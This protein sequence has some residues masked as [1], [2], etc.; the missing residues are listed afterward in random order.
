MKTKCLLFFCLIVFSINNLHAQNFSNKGKDFWL[1]YGYHVSMPY[2]SGNT[3]D[4]IIY[5]T[6]DQ[7]ATVKIDIPG[8]GYSRSY[9][10]TANNVTV[11]D[12]VPKNLLLDARITGPGKFNKGIHITSDNPVVAYAHIYD[13]N[14]SGATL[15]FPTNTLGKDYYSVNYTQKSNEENSNSYFFVVA[16]EDSTSIEITPSAENLNNFPVGVPVVVNLNKGEIYNVMGTTELGS[17]SIGWHGSDLTG[18]RIRSISNSNGTCKPIAVFSGSGKMYIGSHVYGNAD[19]FFAQ[20]FPAKAWGTRYL[21]APTL[22]QP[23]NYFRVCV[24]DSTTIVKVNGVA[25]P[26]SS[27]INGFYYQFKNGNQLG[28]NLPRPNLIE[29]DKPILVA[30]Y[31]TTFGEDGNPNASWEYWNY[32]G[33]IGGDPEM[34]YLSPLEQTINNITLYSADRFE[35]ILSFI[36]IIIRKEG[37]ASFK[38]DGVP[39]S[40]STFESHPGDNNYSYAMIPVYSGVSH[41]LYS[42]SGFNAI[43]YGFGDAESYGYNAGTNIIDLEPSIFIRNDSAKSGVVYT[44]TCVGSP[45]KINVAVP[46]IA[47]NFELSIDSNNKLQG[48]NPFS[49]TPHSYDSIYTSNGKTFYIY[50]IPISYKL[51]SVGVFPVKLVVSSATPQSDGCSNNN[52]QEFISNIYVKEAPIAHFTIQSSGCID[53]IVN[54]VD[55]SVGIG[56]PFY[57]WIWNVDNEEFAYSQNAS[58]K[59]TKFLNHFKLTAITDNGCIATST[60]VLSVSNHPIVNIIAPAVACNNSMIRFF[61]SSYLLAD[62]SFNYLHERIWKI[63]DKSTI[64]TLLTL[65]TVFNQFA[66]IGIKKIQLTVK[67]NTGCSATQLKQI[68]INELPEIPTITSD[69]VCLGE[70]AA[71]SANSSGIIEWYDATIGGHLIK[72][73]NT[74]II[75][76]LSHDTMFFVQS[77]VQGCPASNR[78]VAYVKVNPIPV[79]IDVKN[80]VVCEGEK[81]RLVVH[82]TGLNEWYDA[83][84]NGNMVYSGDTVLT[85][86]LTKDTSFFVKLSLNGCESYN[87]IRVFASVKNNPIIAQ[88]TSDTICIGETAQLIGSSTGML[89][90]YDAPTDGNLLT[91]GSHF[92]INNLLVDTFFYAQ[93]FFNGC[94][95]GVRSIAHVKVNPIPSIPLV[96]NDTICVGEIANI[97]ANSNGSIHWYTELV[98]GNMLGTSNNFTATDLSEDTVYYAQ[99]ILNGCANPVRSP[100]LVKVNNMPTT[101]IVFNDTVCQGQDATL[102][103][104]SNG[105]IQWFNQSV[106]GNI[107]FIGDS[108]LKNNIYSDTIFYTR[109]VL[110]GCNSAFIQAHI[111]VNTIPHSPIVTNDTVCKGDVTLLT[112]SSNGTN[113]W[114]NT[115]SGGNPFFVGDTLINVN[116]IY[117]TILYV[118]SFL[119]GCTDS[120]RTATFVKVN[121]IPAP[122]YVNSDTICYDHST[123]LRAN[124][125]GNNVWFDALTGGNIIFN[126]NEFTTDNL[127]SDTTFYV[128]SFLNGCN[129]LIRTK[130]NIKVNEL[131]LT[132]VIINDTI[133][134]GETAKISAF[135]NGDILWYDAPVNGTI[136]NYGD[137]FVVHHLMQD[138]SLFVQAILKGCKS[139]NNALANIKVNKIPTTPIVTTD[140]ICAGNKSALIAASSGNNSWFD[141]NVGGNIIYEGNT[142]HTNELFQDSI[143][144]VQSFLNGCTNN[145]RSPSSVKVKQLPSAPI[146]TNDTICEGNIPFISAISSYTIEWFSSSSEGNVISANDTFSPIGLNHDTSFYVQ[147]TLNGCISATRTKSTIIVNP[148]PTI[149]TI[150]NDTICEGEVALLKAQSNGNIYWY[151][152]QVGGSLIGVGDTYQST[153]LNNDSF[154]Y[155]HAVL[156]GCTIPQRKI[157]E[158]KVNTVPSTPIVFNDSICSGKT[159][160]LVAT[161]NGNNLW[162]KDSIGGNLIVVNN[163]FETNSLYDDTS[164][165]VQSELN[166]CTNFIRSKA[167][168]IIKPSPPIPIINNDT[169]LCETS[170]VSLHIQP[171]TNASY[172]WSGPLDFS[173]DSANYLLAHLNVLNSGLYQATILLNGCISPVSTMSLTVFPKPENPSILN[174]SPICLNDTLRFF[175]NHINGAIYSWSGP[176]QFKSNEEQPKFKVLNGVDSGN[177][178]LNLTVNNCKSDTV[179]SA[180]KIVVPAISDAGSNQTICSN[181]S[182]IKLTGNIIGG[183]SI[184][185]WTTNGKGYF[186]FNRNN[187]SNEYVL[188]EKD[189]ENNQLQFYLTSTSNN[190]CSADTDSLTVTLAQAP[191]ISI[192]PVLKIFENDTMQLKP[193]IAGNIL[194]YEWSPASFLSNAVIKQPI[195]KGVQDQLLQLKVISADNCVSTSL[196]KTIILKPLIIPN[197]FSPNADGIHDTWLIPGLNNYDG[198]TVNIFDRTGKIVFSSTGYNTPWDGTY[199]GKPLPLATYYY[200]INTMSGKGMYTGSITILR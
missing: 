24:K 37:V 133:C 132:P 92:L 54:L 87:R 55:Q 98:N 93:A 145:V 102:S 8:I 125:S 190:N 94:S 123:T 57:K 76:G 160:T 75:E 56:S 49:Y 130:A 86:A 2:G 90:W 176:N 63:D 27:L 114:Y 61:D 200:I 111:Y 103:A 173:T 169:I 13:Q 127:I 140:T 138:S 142:L 180:V 71:L 188:N 33:Y 53:S 58:I 91:S 165:Y 18:S 72:S 122:P 177:Y 167:S 163:I 126:G 124:S 178:S 175:A 64:D 147:S 141:S 95:N 31:C 164:F 146:V 107:I 30:Q 69:T 97:S 5:L 112:A 101:P 44:E 46:Y 168:I 78:V 68:S 104:L 156:N 25:I 65:D 161:S 198:A 139:A 128:Q 47:N 171:V 6:S 26:T 196:V 20:A 182:T 194:S 60:Q 62:T 157:V 88:I 121:E 51:D 113:Y 154:F 172:F 34:I 59:I 50:Q 192:N 151:N 22:T 150:I 9:Q 15:L 120:N 116:F 74:F 85:S 137:S 66:N 83:P 129:S 183:N 149:A 100:V 136:I 36:N 82:S 35:I 170:T 1:G 109:S 67:T 115:L 84:T 134:E 41:N 117:D 131:P 42:D 184:G 23:N 197:A 99:A 118:Q 12:T 187:L 135:S 152:K 119:N 39:I 144:Y 191:Y 96:V 10:V 148:L 21:T 166:G 14:I 70:S 179:Y 3:Q 162:F 28:A 181:E 186:N 52:Q 189:F 174:N 7:N 158:V 16:T 195:Y 153:K 11:S 17:L 4:M 38:L 19:N 40:S 73:G 108:L 89:N 143:F 32:G 29:A 106:N 43:A 105:T 80:D 199:Q 110:N 77:M 48:N 193:L 79:L 185:Y 155:V 81:A 159:A 45:F